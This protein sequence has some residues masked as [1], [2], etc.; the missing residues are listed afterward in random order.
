MRT[1]HKRAQIPCWL[2]AIF[3]LVP[4][5]AFSANACPPFISPDCGITFH[6]L[7]CT[8]LYTDIRSPLLSPAAVI[9]VREGRDRLKKSLEADIASLL[10]I[11]Q[12]TGA[13]SFSQSLSTE[14]VEKSNQ[15]VAKLRAELE[16]LG[17]ATEILVHQ[18]LDAF[19]NGLYFRTPPHDVLIL[20]PRNAS[21]LLARE[22]KEYEAYVEKRL[23]SLSGH[24]ELQ[25]SG[26]P[27]RIDPLLSQ[28]F[29]AQGA[30][31]TDP[32]LGVGLSLSPSTLFDGQEYAISLVR[33]E[34]RHAKVFLDIISGAKTPY[35][36]RLVD[37]KSAIGPF[38]VYANSFSFDEIEGF[39]ANVVGFQAQLGRETEQL[40]K[41][42]IAN[43][44]EA[45]KFLTR[46]K[47]IQSD[48]K[49]YTERLEGL[50][51][52]SIE[53]SARIR[54]EI[55]DPK[56]SAE[57]FRSRISFETKS[58]IPGFTETAIHLESDTQLKGRK[59]LV[60]IPNDVIKQ[61]PKAIHQHVMTYLV[62]LDSHLFDQLNEL[63]VR[64]A[65]I[66][67]E[68]L[69]RLPPELRPLSARPESN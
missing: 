23:K 57:K 35:R 27:I 21:G 60:Q 3:A 20:K 52:A 2:I 64:L 45:D 12:R 40:A 36:G 49:A 61:G 44:T 56:V 4:S 48:S 46:I 58:N 69:S 51:K 33:H 38:G 59:L 55:A 16:S 11:K 1:W 19:R 29:R 14:V 62:E 26:L 6:S 37:Q 22:L 15:L 42:K 68:P 24:P 67:R 8:P 32:A 54:A 9:A 53:N 66:N 18:N 41:L 30:F 47:N 13:K 65:D 7:N 10:E 39:T 5:Y 43:S 25:A 63:N 28:V 31:S 34:K 50:L 17:F